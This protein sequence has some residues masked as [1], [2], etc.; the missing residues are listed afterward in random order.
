MSIKM[1][2]FKIATLGWYIILIKVFFF[3]LDP[4]ELHDYL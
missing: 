1:L 4:D 3:N 2:I